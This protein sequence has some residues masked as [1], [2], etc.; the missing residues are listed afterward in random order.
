MLRGIRSNVTDENRRNRFSP[1]PD[2]A[3]QYSLRLR[4][5]LTF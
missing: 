5:I 4:D 3:I 1:Y 2:R